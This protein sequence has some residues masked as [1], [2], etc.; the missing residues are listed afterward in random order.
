LGPDGFGLGRAP[1]REAEARLAAKQGI[2]RDQFSLPPDKRH[3]AQI[4][5]LEAE[6]KQVKD[7]HARL[8]TALAQGKFRFSSPSS[9]P[10]NLIAD[11]RKKLGPDRA[12]VEYLVT[13]DSTYAFVL[14]ETGLKT[15]QIPL[16]QQKLRELV[17]SILQP[18]FQVYSGEADLAR[19]GF[20]FAIANELYLQLVRPLEPSFGRASQILIV[21]DDALFYLPFELLVDTLPGR[22]QP[23]GILY[24]NCEQ[25]GFLVR[26]FTMS[27][28]TAAAQVIDGPER[29]G[30]GAAIPALLAMAN[31]TISQDHGALIQ[32]DPVRR[33]LQSA[34]YIGAFAPLPGSTDEVA[35]I[36]QYFPAGRATVLSGPS[37]TETSYKAL[38]P[39]SEIVHL[40]THAIAADD[41]PFYS[42]LILAPDAQKQEDGYLRAYEIVRSP[43]H[44][45]LVVLSACETARG[46]LGRGEGLVGLV[47]AFFQAGAQSVLATQWSIDESTAELM[48]SFYKAMMDGKDTAEAL[49]HAKLEIMK[50]RLS[51]GG[52]EFSLAHPFFWAPFVLIGYGD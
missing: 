5:K 13:D 33:R 39:R 47:S 10:A 26:R 52:T 11:A 18:F 6:L 28:L 34:S 15:F 42:T 14:S 19:L 21:P 3:P 45:R 31:P 29:S 20:D 9:L 50:R 51:L 44:A 8:L 7:E 2:L 46:P 27:Y 32:D 38:S 23:D 22:E 43:L 41:H 40:A 1:A 30:A 12:L 49:R 36:R 35:R 24:S 25:A 16:G 37:A 4:S 17:R 48:G